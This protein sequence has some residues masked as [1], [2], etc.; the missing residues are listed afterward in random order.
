MQHADL[1]HVVELE[2]LHLAAVDEHGMRRGQLERG[3]PYRTRTGRVELAERV[4]QYAVPFQVGGI[5]PA[6][7]RIEHEELD[8]VPDI[9]RNCSVA[10][11]RYELRDPASVGIIGCCLRHEYVRIDAAAKRA[12]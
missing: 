10:E 11:R 6:A 2:T 9:R 7:D 8:A 12:I 4:L 5:Q 3:A 1:V